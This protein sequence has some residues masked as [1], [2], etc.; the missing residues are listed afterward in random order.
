MN[1]KKY[2]KRKNLTPEQYKL[3]NKTMY[4]ILAVCYVIYA[5]IE[6]MNLTAERKDGLFRIVIY[7]IFAI[8][9]EVMVKKKGDKRKAMLFMCSYEKRISI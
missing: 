1:L 6:I 2:T 9:S 7:L 8:A 3:A 5:L 4:I